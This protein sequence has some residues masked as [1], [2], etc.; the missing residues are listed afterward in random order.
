MLLQSADQA[1]QRHKVFG[2]LLSPAERTQ[3]LDFGVVKSFQ[4]DDV[5]C[6]QG[7]LSDLMYILLIGEAEVSEDVDDKKIIVGKLKEGELFGEISALY[8]VPRISTV[9]VCKPTVVIEVSSSVLHRLFDANLELRQAVMERLRERLI[10]S[11]LKVIPA[12][13]PLKTNEMQELL[14]CSGLACYPAGGLIVEEKEAGDALYVVIHGEARVC[15]SEDNEQIN[16]AVLYTGDYFGERALLTG[17]PRAASVYAISKVEVVLIERGPFLRFIQEN[18]SVCESM[19]MTSHNRHA[20]IT[21]DLPGDDLAV[22]TS[23]R[24]IRELTRK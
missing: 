19:D 18:P 21:G 22:E 13:R 14:N 23:R 1:L 12:F 16:L 11:T 5:L 7:E 4:T 2:D 6:Q 20:Q 10:E 8:N 15:Y 24:A 3:L 9:T 17:A